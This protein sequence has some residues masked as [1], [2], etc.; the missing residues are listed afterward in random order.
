LLLFF[1]FMKYAITQTSGKQFFLKPGQWY[2]VDYIGRGKEGS[3][4]SLEKILFFRQAKQIQ[5]GQ[6]FLGKSQIP[7]RI[8]QTVKGKKITVLKTKPKKHYTRTKGHRA[9]YTRI[10]ITQLETN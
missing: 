4:L 7:A 3:F 9:L 6:P 10:Q 2:D 5:L 8:I 1:R